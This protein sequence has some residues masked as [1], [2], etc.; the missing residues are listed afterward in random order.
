MEPYITRRLFGCV[1]VAL[2]NHSVRARSEARHARSRC[3]GRAL[4]RSMS[5]TL[6]RAKAFTFE[7]SERLEVMAPGG[8]KRAPLF[9][10][11]VTVRRPDALFFELHERVT[12]RSILPPTTTAGPSPWAKGRR[13]VG[14]DRRSRYA[15]RDAGRCR[16]EVRSTGADRRCSL[17]L[18]LRRFHRQ[19]F[20]GR[21]RRAGNDRRCVLC[22]AGLRRRLCAGEALASG[23]GPGAAR[24]ARDRLQAASTYVPRE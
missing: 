15:R 17:Q 11:K 9:T 19:Q 2:F 24:P 22:E 12:R 18:A 6:A 5:D 21:I 1:A 14:A 8:E 7:T 3:R 23:F 16:P 10:R 20:A 13:G 4:M